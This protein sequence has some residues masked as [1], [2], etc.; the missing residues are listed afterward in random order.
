MLRCSRWFSKKRSMFIITIPNYQTDTGKPSHFP[1]N[2]R[3]LGGGIDEIRIGIRSPASAGMGIHT[4]IRSPAGACAEIGTGTCSPA[5]A[6]AEICTGI[7]SPAEARAEICTGTCSPAETCA[8]ICSGICS[9]T[10]EDADFSTP[11]TRRV[12]RY[13]FPTNVPRMG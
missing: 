4:G 10:G 5:E 8:E 3:S 13:I 7:C 9:P 12:E 6:C 11:A 2:P 1:V